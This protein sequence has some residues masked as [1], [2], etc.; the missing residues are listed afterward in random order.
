MTLSELFPPQHLLGEL[1]ASDFGQARSELVDHLIL[2]KSIPADLRSTIL[3]ALEKREQRLSTAI[4]NGIM[5]PHASLSGLGSPVGAIG[6]L[7]RPLNLDTPDH[8]PVHWILLV[9]VPAEGYTTHLRT[10]AMVSRF[11]N[12]Q[13]VL[14]SLAQ[15]K[16][17]TNLFELIQSQSRNVPS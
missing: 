15:I 13:A 6:R 16:D 2:K 8:L 1:Q 10:L 9:I 3:E 4:G 5:L 17:M 12:N 14:D 11:L 7:S